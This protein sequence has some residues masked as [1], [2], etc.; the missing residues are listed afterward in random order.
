[1]VARSVCTNFELLS[2]H[3]HFC[4]LIFLRLLQQLASRITCTEF[5]R[6]YGCRPNGE[7]TALLR[8]AC[9][10]APLSGTG[11]AGSR[12]VTMRVGMVG[13]V[14]VLQ[15]LGN[16]SIGQNE[17]AFLSISDTIRKTKLRI[18][19]CT[20]PPAERPLCLPSSRARAH[21]YGRPRE[22]RARESSGNITFRGAI[23]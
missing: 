19:H 14:P 6:K 2:H 12:G 1:M 10:T 5:Q 9:C 15:E 8:S 16:I 23:A 18:S 17:Y 7:Y 20:P 22:T 11:P 13:T 21:G 3:V 4:S